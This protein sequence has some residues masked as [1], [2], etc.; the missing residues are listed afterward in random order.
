[1]S[2]IIELATGCQRSPVGRRTGGRV[3]EIRWGW[4]ASFEAVALPAGS[5]PAISA[6]G[7][8]IFARVASLPGVLI[9]FPLCTANLFGVSPRIFLMDGARLLPKDYL[10]GS[11]IAVPGLVR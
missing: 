1:L 5:P 6:A 4:D 3:T 10:L 8:R 2:T 9:F 11:G 7:H